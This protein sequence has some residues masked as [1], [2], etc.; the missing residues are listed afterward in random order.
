MILVLLLF[1]QLFKTAV[2][3]MHVVN[4]ILTSAVGCLLPPLLQGVIIKTKAAFAGRVGAPFLQPYYDL[5]KLFR[6]DFVISSTT[7]WVFLAGTVISLVATIL[8]SLILPFGHDGDVP[9]SFAGDMILFAYLF[10]LARFFMTL[11][12]LDTG[13]P[14][15]G[16]GAA[17]EVTFACL[18]EPTHVLRPAGAGR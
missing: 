9:I 3:A 16:M 10:G 5:I 1:W 18:A 12:S 2:N 11:A 7:T 6:K 17:R 4:I 14:F 13:S 15:E 8:A